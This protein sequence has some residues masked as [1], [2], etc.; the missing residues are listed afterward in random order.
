[1]YSIILV[2]FLDT[3]ASEACFRL[4][5]VMWWWRWTCFRCLIAAYQWWP[6]QWGKAIALD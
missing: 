3:E 4:L 2:L 5:H 1:M 6:V